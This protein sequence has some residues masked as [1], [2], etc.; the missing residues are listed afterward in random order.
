MCLVVTATTRLRVLS[1]TATDRNE[2]S[3]S[4]NQLLSWLSDSFS[5]N[6]L[7]DQR[8][9]HVP[10]YANQA[11]DKGWD[12]RIVA[13]LHVYVGRVD[14]R[15]RRF[16]QALENR[17]ETGRIEATQWYVQRILEVVCPALMARGGSNL[18]SWKGSSRWINLAS[19]KESEP[20]LDSRG[21]V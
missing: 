18:K 5:M 4:N 1:R 19:W 13:G 11:S 3:F 7:W 15:A 14:G 6:R 9:Y 8:K 2:E 10:L 16:R 12:N 17:K 21:A 20:S